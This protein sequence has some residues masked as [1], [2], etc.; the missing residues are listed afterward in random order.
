MALQIQDPR[1]R[2]TGPFSDAPAA[3]GALP[4]APVADTMPTQVVRPGAMQSAP[5]VGGMPSV[6]NPLS[7][8]TSALSA[9][10]QL[11]PGEAAPDVNP[12]SAGTRFGNTL[13]SA[14]RGVVNDQVSALNTVNRA[15]A[16]AANALS[17]LPRAALGF[18]RDT[19]RAAL[20]MDPSPNAGQ[21]IGG[22]TAPQLKAPFA[23]PPVDFAL[24]RSDVPVRNPRAAAPTSAVAAAGGAGGGP[25]ADPNFNPAAD[26]ISAGNL[27]TVMKPSFNAPRAA[28]ASAAQAA[29]VAGVNVEGGRTLPVGA[30]VNGVPTFSDGTGGIARTMTP[31]AMTQLAQERSISRADVGAASN[32]L[33]SDALGGATP[34]QGQM[35]D[36][37]LAQIRQPITGSRPSAAQFAEA[38]RLAIASRDPRSAAGIAARNLAMEAGYA[39]TPRLRR[40]A[41]TALANLQAS[42]QQSALA[43][44]QAEAQAAETASTGRNALDA[45]QLRGTLEGQNQLANTALEARLRPP[46]AGQQVQLAD[47]TIGLISPTTGA[48]T[49]ATL[50]DGTVAKGQPKNPPPSILTTVGGGPALKA[51]TDNILGADPLT[52]MIPDKNAPGGKRLPTNEEQFAAQQ[53]A[54]AQLQQLGAGQPDAAAPRAPAVGTVSGGYRFKGGDPASQ[55]NW[56]KV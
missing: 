12:Q 37:R 31:E 56:E 26:N 30:M 46:A 52:G 50:P 45:I 36:Q 23:P 11:R 14:R 8:M 4:A 35:V 55:S 7:S 41:E 49:R 19:T 47:G 33:A 32:V 53:K 3:A 28:A 6:P 27:A 40:M 16:G 38:D 48:I 54:Y 29:P 18:T 1:Q 51:Q 13:R 20:G 39:R 43:G 22:I 25:A 24:T 34:T 15:G 2:R 5:S 9:P 17:Y 42:T 21:P 44:Q 10:R